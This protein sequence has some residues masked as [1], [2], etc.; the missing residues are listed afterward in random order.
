M[1]EFS[2]QEIRDLARFFAKRFPS[3]EQRTHIAGMAGLGGSAQLSGEPEAAWSDLVRTAVQGGRMLHLAR[4]AARQRPSDSNLKSLVDTIEAGR[5]VRLGGLRL[6]LGALAIILL[7]GLVWGLSRTSLHEQGEPPVAA[8]PALA[9]AQPAPAPQPAAGGP[10]LSDTPPTAS[11]PPLTGSP[12]TPDDPPPAAYDASAP[13]ATNPAPPLPGDAPVAAPTGP[14]V[15]PPEPATPPL[16]EGRCG[17]PQGELLGYWYAGSDADWAPAAVHTISG[18]ANVRASYPS[19]ENNW[20]ARARV[21]C[22]LR[23]GDQVRI[24]QPPVWV[25]GGAWWVPFHAG[26]LQE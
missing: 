6:G 14:P 18:G 19:R 12:A 3:F 24:S 21:V 17:G 16:V 23:N 2:E 22:G 25:V 26:D 13:E 8:P 9:S 20:N 4:S 1:M 5:S 11:A 15:P 7:A 10:L